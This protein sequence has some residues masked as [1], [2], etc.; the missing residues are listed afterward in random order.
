MRVCFTFFVHSIQCNLHC[1]ILEVPFLDCAVLCLPFLDVSQQR[2][3][4]S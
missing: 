3:R 2:C 4:Y 1:G